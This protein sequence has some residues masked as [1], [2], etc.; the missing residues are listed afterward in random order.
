[1]SVTAFQQ[2]WVELSLA[3]LLDASEVKRTE[4][5]DCVKWLIPIAILRQKKQWE[6]LDFGFEHA[7]T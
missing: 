5:D 6:C 7:H 1:M 2:F 4:D 3:E